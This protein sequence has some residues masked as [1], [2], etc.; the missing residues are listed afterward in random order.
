MSIFGPPSSRI[1]S[2]GPVCGDDN[3]TTKAYVDSKDALR[4]L[5]SGGTITGILNVDT[6]ADPGRDAIV[7]ITDTAIIKLENRGIGITNGNLAVGTSAGGPEIDILQASTL[8]D[9]GV[10]LR[11][12]TNTEFYQLGWNDSDRLELRKTDATTAT[13]VCEFTADRITGLQDP[14]AP[15]DAATKNYVD[16]RKPLVTVWAENN[17]AIS[18]GEYQWS[19]G[20]GANGNPNNGY[21]MMAAGRIL[22]MGLTAT[23]ERAPPPSGV[24]VTIVVNGVEVPAYRVVKR[25]GQYSGTT[26]F[27]N[28]LQ[29]AEGFI[30]NFRSRSTNNAV[31]SAVVS[32][33]IELD[34]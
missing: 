34:F 27:R 8:P 32:L 24:T 21:T 23:A 29:I 6:A 18:S 4:V 12:V 7:A 22:R 5:R 30:I 14:V 17:N 1:G 13:T 20:N 25:T 33:L 10:R 2:G 19:F 15:S 31:A 28:P 11:N 3:H 9:G 16:S 26:T